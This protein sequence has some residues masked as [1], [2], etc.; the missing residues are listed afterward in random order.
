MNNDNTVIFLLENFEK[1]LRFFFNNKYQYTGCMCHWFGVSPSNYTGI[2]LKF[3]K[4]Y[5]S[6]STEQLPQAIKVFS[7]KPLVYIS[8]FL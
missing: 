8:T 6:E 3:V 1:L 7:S 2:E 4:R 5:Y